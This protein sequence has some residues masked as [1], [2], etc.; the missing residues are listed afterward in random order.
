MLPTIYEPKLGVSILNSHCVMIE[1][2]N[3]ILAFEGKM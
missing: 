2:F 3:I 1:P